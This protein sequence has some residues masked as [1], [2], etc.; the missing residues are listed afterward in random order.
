MADPRLSGTTTNHCLDGDH[1]KCDCDAW[2]CWCF[3]HRE[4]RGG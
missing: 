3:C 2:E 1:D 4:V